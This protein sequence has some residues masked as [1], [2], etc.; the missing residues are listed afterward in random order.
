MSDS[1]VTVIVVEYR[2]PRA[3]FGVAH[4]QAAGP[5]SGRSLVILGPAETPR[6]LVRGSTGCL[7]LVGARQDGRRAV[8]SCAQW[9]IGPVTGGVACR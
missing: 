2:D 5:A 6:H 8:N 1:G 4:R 3:R 7:A 9:A